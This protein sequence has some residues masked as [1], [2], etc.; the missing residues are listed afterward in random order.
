MPYRSGPKRGS[1]DRES[2]RLRTR[3]PPA[4]GMAMIRQPPTREDLYMRRHG[5]LRLLADEELMERVRSGEAGAFEIV[6]DRHADPAFSLAYRML[7]SRSAAED[8]VQD[9]FLAAWRNARRYQPGLGSVRTWLLGIVHHRAVDALRRHT[10]HERRRGGDET[11]AER[12]PAAEL[13][14]VEA[15]RRDE[16][17]GVRAA[18]DGL[19]AEQARVIELAYYGGFTHNEIADMLETPLG[20]VKGRMR[21]GLEKLRDHLERAAS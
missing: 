9:A 3:P 20:T 21:L 16:A 18:L 7:G 19:P 15:V 5:D 14:D 13:T 12:Q 4:A 11:A 2:G 17:R 10:V 1:P 6:Y 8:V